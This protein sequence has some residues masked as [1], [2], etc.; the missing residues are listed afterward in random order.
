M[1]N[2]KQKAVLV[3]TKHRGV[4]FGYLISHEGDVATLRDARM[5]IYWSSAMRGLLG[6]AAMG[7]DRQCK[8]GPAVDIVLNDVTAVVDVKSEAVEKW[9]SAPWNS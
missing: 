1:P 5:C 9:E 2:K 6:L 7:P 3:T 8:V 4:F